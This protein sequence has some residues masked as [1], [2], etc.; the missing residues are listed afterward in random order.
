[1]AY[2]NVPLRSV[3]EQEMRKIEARRLAALD[4]IQE[5]KIMAET[6]NGNEQQNEY[7]EITIK[8]PSKLVGDPF[9]AKDGKEYVTVKLPNEG[10]ED[11]SPWASFVVPTNHV[12]K[13][14]Y[15][16]DKDV[17]WTKLPE[18]GHTTV[19][20][21]VLLGVGEDGKN[22]WETIKKQVSNV[23]LKKMFEE[24]TPVKKPSLLNNLDSKKKDVDALKQSV[25]KASPQKVMEGAE[26]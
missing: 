1:M 9:A 24:R 13:D 20:K 5:D 8:F 3:V 18:N 25:D 6:K 23:D 26:R 11:K 21:P 16:T 15:I 17:S 4:S 10:K 12:H 14:Q 22:I 7:K 2:V 19:T